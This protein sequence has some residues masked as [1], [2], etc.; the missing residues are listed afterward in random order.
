MIDAPPPTSEP[1]LTTTP[2]EMRLSHH[3]GAQ[4]AG[5]VATKLL[6]GIGGARRQVAYRRS[7]I[8]DIRRYER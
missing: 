1:S 3:R 2:A 5:V 6:N 7:C 4:G 8:G